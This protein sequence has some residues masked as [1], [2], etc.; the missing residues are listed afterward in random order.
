MAV[1]LRNSEIR[2]IILDVSRQLIIEKGVN[3]TSL[4]EIAA[5][6]GISKGTLF[7]YYPTK[8]DLIFEVTD[9]HFKQMTSRMADWANQV[10]G[11]VDPV[12]I[13]S[14]VYQSIVGDELRGK[15]H[16]Y[17]IE[18]AITENSGLKV[19]FSE[20]YQ[21][22]TELMCSSLQSILPPG[23]D[24]KTLAQIIVSSLDGLVI[25]AILGMQ[26]FPIQHIVRY[27]LDAKIEGVQR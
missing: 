2:Q 14:Y 19:R 10:S 1:T 18:Q 12:E 17:L 21:E 9:Q 13:V 15:L 23:A 3:N 22:W 24:V 16:H 8:S 27:L 7:Y 20:K 26:D 6:A 5:T 4:A 11:E 25:Q